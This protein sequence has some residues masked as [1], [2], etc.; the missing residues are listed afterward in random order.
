ME[1]R[2]EHANIPANEPEELAK[3]Y[4]TKFDLKAEQH[5]VRGDG[6]LIAFQKG[7]PIGQPDVLHIGFN[8]GT[9]TRLIEWCT[10]FTGE[11]KVGPE[12][13]SFQLIDPEGN[14]VEIYAAND[15]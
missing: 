12:F 15:S 3:W 10:R 13:S 1:F 2:L 11:I 7:T 8:V 4:A 5:L 14:C 9:K 6:V